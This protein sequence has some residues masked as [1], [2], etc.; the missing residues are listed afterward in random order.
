[1]IDAAMIRLLEEY[2]KVCSKKPP[3]CIL[4]YYGACNKNCMYFKGKDEDDDLAA[5]AKEER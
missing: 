3:G 2:E 1:M 4:Y 5:E